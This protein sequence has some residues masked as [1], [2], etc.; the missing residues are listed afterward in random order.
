MDWT[1]QRYVLLR[2]E[3]ARSK[4]LITRKFVS[5]QVG[6]R[7]MTLRKAPTADRCDFPMWFKTRKHWH[8]IM[9][10]YGYAFH[11][12]DGSM[13]ITKSSGVLETRALC[14]QINKQTPTEVMAVVHYTTGW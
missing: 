4:E 13:H 9:G 6:S 3:E 7:I 10:N 2:M 8:S 1:V 11:Q 5:V 14:E 12:S